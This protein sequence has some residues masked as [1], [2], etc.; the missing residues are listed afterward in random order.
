MKKIKMLLGTVCACLSFLLLFSACNTAPSN[1]GASPEDAMS[2]AQ[3]ALDSMDGKPASGNSSSQ[4]NQASPQGGRSQQNVTV[5]SGRKPAW[6][7]SVDSVFNRSQYAAAVGYAS[8]REMAE[9][10]AFA[11]LTALFGQSIQADQRI[12]NTYTEAVRNGAASWSDNLEMQNTIIT[13]SSLD[14]LLGAE[15]KEVWHDTRNNVFY[16]AAV[17]E[18]RRAVELYNNMI[19]ANLNMIKNL[20]T[21]SQS[22]KNSF[23]G[24]SRYQLAAAVADVNVT[25]ENLVR[26]VGGAPP[27]GILK[28]DEYRVEAQNI[29]RAIPIGIVVSNDRSG[30]IQ[31]AFAK[32]LSELGFRSGGGGSRYVLRVDVSVSPVD[33]PN[34][35]NKFARME[36][37]ANLSDTGA[38]SVL[39]P[40]NFNLR[41]GHTSMPEAENRVFMSAERRINAEYKNILSDY[42]SQLLPKK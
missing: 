19:Q 40:W 1:S 2:L 7:D 3:S 33:L 17:M 13:S 5:S 31:G 39:L 12:T 23:E 26:T 14:T 24:L 27:S 21:M 28:G 34:N 9:K 20:T 10:N 16:A 38:G 30:R 36:L 32:A 22:E 4:R 29:T 18:K 35:P 42:L 41:E 8:S 6:V 25:Y 37:G 11:N 15:I